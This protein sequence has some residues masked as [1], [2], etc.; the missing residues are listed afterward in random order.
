MRHSDDHCLV[1]LMGFL[2][3]AHTALFI[4]GALLA[5]E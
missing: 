3:G 4:V 5:L 1:A 2:L